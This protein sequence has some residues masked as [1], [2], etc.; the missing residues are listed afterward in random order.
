M[1]R[2]IR[3]TAIFYN[4]NCGPETYCLPF[5][6]MHL[7]QETLSPD[8]IPDYD[9]V[10]FFCGPVDGTADL[11]IRCYG[12]QFYL[13]VRETNLHNSE[14]Q[15]EFR[16]LL[17]KLELDDS[18]QAACETDPMEDLC[19]WIAQQCNHRMRNFASTS[20]QRLSLR[21]WLTTETQFLDLKVEN[22]RVIVADF[23]PDESLI[24]SLIPSLKL[25]PELQVD[26]PFL[27]PS[28]IFLPSISPSQE[29]RPRRVFKETIPYFFKPASDPECMLRE[30]TTLLRINRLS[31]NQVCRP[32]LLCGL[33]MSP[34]AAGEICGVLL[35]YIDHRKVL[36]EVNMGAESPHTLIEWIKQLK[37]G[38]H[39]LHQAGIIWGDAKPENILIDKNNDLRIVDFEGGYTE[40]WVDQ[41][42]AGSLEGDEQALCRIC[43]YLETNNGCKI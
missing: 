1:A 31:S 26:V 9:I 28:T 2:L 16:I 39:E 12:K 10:D 43:Q 15:R 36:S 11:T 23:E 30:I 5:S 17:K 37:S 34:H 20:S 35:E 40:G 4:S 14:V 6:A 8:N 18:Q 41:D 13:R 42:K 33:V 24:A 27:D 22:Q 19:F 7:A 29:C 3:T 38:L 32:A 21:D 25:P